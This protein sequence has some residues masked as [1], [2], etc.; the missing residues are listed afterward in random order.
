[1]EVVK[2]AK[3]RA[4]IER[5]FLIMSHLLHN[6]DLLTPWTAARTVSHSAPE[7]ATN[8][9]TMPKGIALA[10]VL[11]AIAQVLAD[12]RDEE[13]DKE[14]RLARSGIYYLLKLQRT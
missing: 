13:L 12:V 10:K 6:L 5:S 1:M 2:D 4:A 7:L 3:S 9:A 8:F 11:G 14:G